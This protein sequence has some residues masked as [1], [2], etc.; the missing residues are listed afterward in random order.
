MSISLKVLQGLEND[1]RL[2]ILE[3]KGT[4]LK[5]QYGKDK[6]FDLSLEYPVTEPPCDFSNELFKLIET[7]RTGLHRYMENAGYVD[8]RAAI[9]DRLAKE[10]GL[11]FTSNEVVMTSGSTGAI[12]LALKALLNPGEEVIL[13]APFSKDY[14]AY[15]GNHGGVPKI[16]STDSEFIPDLTALEASITA[17]TK[18]VIINSPHNPTGTV[19]SSQILKQIADI[20]VRKSEFLKSSIYVISD[21]IYRNFYYRENICPWIVHYY[22]N[23]ITVNSYSR[24]FSVPGERIGYAAVH[25]KCQEAQMVFGGLIY[26]NRTLG[27]VNAPALMQNTVRGVTQSSLNLDEYRSKED[28]IYN[29]LIQL[30]YSIIK[31]EGAFYL[32]PSTPIKD[33]FIFANELINHRV[34]TIPGSAYQSPGHIRISFC[35]DLHVLEGSLMGFQKAIEKFRIKK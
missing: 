23:T 21:D 33:D 18:A 17:K 26:S 11:R 12:N 14:E 31:P 25:P 8:T 2:R 15:I 27:F 22:A 24:E 20:L 10:S 6:V 30:G 19:Y 34:L 28:F 3:A 32:F 13:I 16:I 29:H 35:V 7:P 5:M 9:A 4:A 1:N